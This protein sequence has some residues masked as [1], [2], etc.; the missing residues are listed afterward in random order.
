MVCPCSLDI[1]STRK[2]HS[3]AKRLALEMFRTMLSKQSNTSFIHVLWVNPMTA[4][5]NTNI[6][7]KVEVFI[8]L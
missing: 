5:L 8:C 1:R 3:S 4:E 7:A 2:S 6:C